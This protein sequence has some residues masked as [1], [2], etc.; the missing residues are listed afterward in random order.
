MAPNDPMH[1]NKPSITYI[2]GAWFGFGAVR[3]SLW[4]V[5]IRQ[6]D[7]IKVHTLLLSVRIYDAQCCLG[8]RRADSQE[9]QGDSLL[10]F[11][12]EAVRD[13][14]IYLYSSLL[15]VSPVEMMVL[16]E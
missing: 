6:S 8:N 4:P 13:L 14:M 10:R 16:G 2:F 7:F 3:F 15:L 11:L 12:V 5:N 1:H 9:R